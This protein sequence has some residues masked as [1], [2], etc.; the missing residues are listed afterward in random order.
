MGKIDK[1]QQ[2]THSKLL[3]VV[4]SAIGFATL[5]TTTPEMISVLSKSLSDLENAE[6]RWQSERFKRFERFE[7]LER[8]KEIERKGIK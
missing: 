1:R 2:C 8:L 7:K 5:L 3:V 4:T 6:K